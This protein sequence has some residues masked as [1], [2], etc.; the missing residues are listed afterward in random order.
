MKKAFILLLLI[1]FQSNLMAQTDI[2][3]KW[4]TIDDETGKVKSIVDIYEKDGKAYGKIIKIFRGAEEEQDPICDVCPGDRKNKKIVG[5]EIIRGMELDKSDNEWDD[6]EI[7]DPQSGK[8]Y[9]CVI[10]KEDE[11]LKVRGYIAFL[12]RTQTWEKAE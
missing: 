4:K 1:A 11:K 10:W 2:F 5:L 12:Y 7:L 6:G 3:G 9:D 8:I